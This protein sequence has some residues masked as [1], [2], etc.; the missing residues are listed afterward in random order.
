MS[1][2]FLKTPEYVKIVYLMHVEKETRF[3][4]EK[5]SMMILLLDIQAL[6]IQMQKIKY[7]FFS[8]T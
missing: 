5:N 8:M 4:Q 3:G 6:L 2:K 1:K 7:C